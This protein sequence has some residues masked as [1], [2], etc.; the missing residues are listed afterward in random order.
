MTAQVC[1]HPG[2][3]RVMLNGY[4]GGDTSKRNIADYARIALDHAVGVD[5]EQVDAARALLD[6]ADVVQLR[7]GLGRFTSGNGDDYC[8]DLDDDELALLR[9][10][11]G[12]A[13]EYMDLNN[14]ADDGDFPDDQAAARAFADS[15]QLQCWVLS[16]R[17]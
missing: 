4:F 9:D 10:T 16:A 11:L 7:L 12:A 6:R 2:A 15:D 8:V 3:H 14:Y 1:T 13:R 17:P 5:E